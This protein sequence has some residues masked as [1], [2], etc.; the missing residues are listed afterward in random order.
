VK[1]S[2]EDI[3]QLFMKT[4]LYKFNEM[5]EYVGYGYIR[6]NFDRHINMKHDNIGNY[7]QFLL[8]NNFDF[9]KEKKQK[10]LHHI[11]LYGACEIFE[12]FKMF[13]TDEIVKHCLINN[14]EA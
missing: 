2:D 9:D 3:D 8:T 7:I 6:D 14:F 5:L 10:L 12:R 13:D 4:S 1:L 11:L